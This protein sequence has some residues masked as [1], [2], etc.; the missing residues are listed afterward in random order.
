MS[1]PTKPTPGEWRAGGSLTPG[2]IGIECGSWFIAELYGLIEAKANARLIAAAPEMYGLCKEL[3]DWVHGKR[4]GRC[5]TDDMAQR[6][7]VAIAKVE[8]RS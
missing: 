3:M 1:D 2:R 6:L 4:T 7:S 8:G 5:L